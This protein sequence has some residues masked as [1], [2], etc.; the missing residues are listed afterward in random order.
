M[1]DDIAFENGE[2]RWI[3]ILSYTYRPPVKAVICMYPDDDTIPAS[4]EIED[5]EVC[6]MDTQEPLTDEEY[7]DHEDAIIETISEHEAH[8]RN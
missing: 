8:K 1:C 7:K 2:G 3:E 6:W 4:E 5:V